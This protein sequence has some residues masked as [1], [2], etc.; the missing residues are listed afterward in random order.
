MSVVPIVVLFLRDHPE[1]VGLLPYGA[2]GA[3]Y[4]RAHRRAR[5]VRPVHAA[6]GALGDAWRSG[7][8]W[9]LFGSFLVCGLSTNGLIQTHFLSAA[10]DHDITASTAAGYLALIGIFDVVGTIALGLA[11]RPL[12]P[13]LPARRL[14]RAAR[15]QPDA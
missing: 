3:A 14:L 2:T 10:H 11:H 13:P 12:R 9:L 1:D 5:D 15:V 7:V 8:F 6:F 4:R